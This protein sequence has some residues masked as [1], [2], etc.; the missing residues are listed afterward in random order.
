MSQRL[1]EYCLNLLLFRFVF[2]KLQLLFLN[3]NIKI[4]DLLDPTACGL[5]AIFS[6]ING[7]KF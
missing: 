6:Y 2:S 4:N 3:G 1:E 7:T 5:K